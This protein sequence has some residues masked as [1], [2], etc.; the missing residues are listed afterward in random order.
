MPC[1]DGGSDSRDYDDGRSVGEST[2]YSKGYADAKRKYETPN[3]IKLEGKFNENIDRL[4]NQVIDLH[5]KNRRL[6]ESL[7]KL[8]A[9]KDR[10]NKLEASLCALIT[11]LE[12][13]D[14]ANDVI[15]QASRSGLI[16]LMKFWQ[17]HRQEDEARLANRIHRMFSEHE[18]EVIKNLLNK[19]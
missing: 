10:N 15:S 4:N 7:D 17:D 3:V 19:K 12:K 11:E 1:Y 6:Q 14:I 13:R 18:Q 5:K 8:E 9:Q 2:G 16:D